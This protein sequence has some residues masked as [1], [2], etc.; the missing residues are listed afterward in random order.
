M[1]RIW[2]SI[3]KSSSDESSRQ[4]YQNICMT[5]SL[6][7]RYKFVKREAWIYQMAIKTILSNELDAK[8][9]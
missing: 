7:G 4:Y 6:K 5:F 9:F 2:Y 8:Y 1:Y 3:L